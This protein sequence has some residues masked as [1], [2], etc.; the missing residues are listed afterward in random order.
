MYLLMSAFH[1]PPWLKLISNRSRR[2]HSEPVSAAYL[3]YQIRTAL[4]PVLDDC[5]GS[6]EDAAFLASDRASGMSGTVTSVTG[7]EVVD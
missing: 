1:S 6:G 3:V 7:G 5:R 4:H 2:S